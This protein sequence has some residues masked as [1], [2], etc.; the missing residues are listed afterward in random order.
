M[1]QFNYCLFQVGI[2]KGHLAV[3]QCKQFALLDLVTFIVTVTCCKG[4]RTG[5]NSFISLNHVG[6]IL[7]AVCFRIKCQHCRK[8][9]W[10]GSGLEN[11]YFTV[12]QICCLFCCH[13]DVFVIW[14]NKN[15]FCCSCMDCGKNI[16]SRW[17]HGLATA[18][19]VVNTQINKQLFYTF[20]CCNCNKTI[21]FIRVN[22]LIWEC[23]LSFCF[24][25]D[26]LVVIAMLFF[27]VIDLHISQITQLQCCLNCITWLIG[28]YMTLD[29]LFIINYNNTVT[30]GFQICTQ[31]K[32]VCIRMLFVDNKLGAI[33][34]MN[35]LFIELCCNTVCLFL[36]WSC[37]SF[38]LGRNDL[39][40]FD[41]RQHTFPDF[42][43]A[44]TACIDN[45]CLF[46][47]RKHLR[48][49]CKRILCCRKDLFPHHHFG[50][51]FL[52]GNLL[53]MFRSK[54]CNGQNSTLCRLHN[55]FI[56]SRNTQRQCM[57]NILCVCFFFAFQT[58]GEST[59]QQR[60]NNTGVSSR[61]TQKSR[62]CLFGY[63]LNGWIILEG[64][65]FP[66]CSVDGHR[67]ICTGITIRYREY[68]ERVYL[69]SA[70]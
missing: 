40:V 9:L 28:M 34:E 19:N 23:W 51:F 52:L 26:Q 33:A 17:V 60:K 27:H 69:L 63:L 61:T 47:Y 12:C 31:R 67:H 16:I 43:K 55:C 42:H 66:F 53:C 38:F 8:S 44:L 35:I 24:Q 11:V 32:R 48:S 3:F 70:I 58:F 18:D 46:K 54:S 30:D 20:A 68:I 13:D 41:Y 64:F 37:L 15:S 45:A 10:D 6:N 14:K 59:E 4:N 29:D 2:N 25:I 21:F 50:Y 62:S 1:G 7:F 49:L 22:S 5:S 36:F 39:F 65:Q 56:S 57:R